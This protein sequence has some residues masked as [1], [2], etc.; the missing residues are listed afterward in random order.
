VKNDLKLLMLVPIFGVAGAAATVAMWYL[1]VFTLAALTPPSHVVLGCIVSG[2]IG[3]LAVACVVWPATRDASNLRW[4]ACIG[5][6]MVF[7][8]ELA[9][10]LPLGFMTVAFHGT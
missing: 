1:F 10:Y 9:F 7:A 8:T 2:L 5:L 4:P 6:G 3:P